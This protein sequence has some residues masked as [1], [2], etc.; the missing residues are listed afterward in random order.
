MKETVSSLKRYF[1]LVGFFGSIGIPIALSPIV[2]ALLHPGVMGSIWVLLAALGLCGLFQGLVSLA[3]VFFGIK[4]EKML[5]DQPEFICKTLKASMG[6]S[7]FSVGLQ[8]YLLGP[9]PNN[10]AMFAVGI[11]IS[12]YLLVQVRRLS[13][14]VREVDGPQPIA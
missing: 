4:L 10:L 8:L 6:V 14:Q 9:L 1:L 3:F 7:V 13:A 5:R 12:Y 2:T 11:L